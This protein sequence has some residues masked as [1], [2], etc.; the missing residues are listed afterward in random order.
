MA[1][2]LLRA[3]DVLDGDENACAVLRGFPPLR[4][5]SHGTG[6]ASVAVSRSDC[7]VVGSA[8]RALVAP[9]R[10]ARSVILIRNAE[11]AVAVNH[12]RMVGCRVISIS[13]GG[14]ALP[15]ALRVAI[16]RAVEQGVIVMAAAGQPLPAVVQPACFP[17]CLAVAATTPAGTPWALSARG[18]EV[19]WSAPG[20][21]VLVAH[22]ANDGEQDVA[23][24]S[25]TSFSVALSA[26]VAA[27]W[28]AHH[29]PAIRKTFD[30]P[31]VQAAFRSLVRETVTPPPPG[32]S[33]QKYG[34][35]IINARN[36]L[37]ADLREARP[38]ASLGSADPVDRIAAFGE[39]SAA[40]LRT[41]LS[42]LFTGGDTAL[43]HHADELAF[44]VAEHAAVRAEVFGDSAAAGL[45][46][47][48]SV[49]PLAAVASPALRAA[50]T[51]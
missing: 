44:R 47:D 37:E 4:F 11:L 30:P 7:R 27:L 36:L 28:L 1:L 3:R 50:L 45:G 40:A 38:S 34:P 46:G 24:H 16:K 13:L 41:R 22:T 48:V 21:R 19:D 31:E 12:A 2:D 33:G 9:I 10:T 6:T 20:S 51:G 5:P 25:G 42:G 23:F 26:G 18:P 17:E 8:P 43:A 39:L 49:S 35:G 15:T 32:W 14:I 29:G